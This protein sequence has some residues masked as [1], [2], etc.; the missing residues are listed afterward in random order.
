MPDFEKL[1]LNAFSRKEYKP[2]KAKTLAR[3]LGVTDDD[4][5]SFRRALRDLIAQGKA[6][7][8]N[9]HVIKP[10]GSRSAIIG[11]YRRFQSG[12]GVVRTVPLPGQ[13][14]GEYFIGSH[15]A[16]DAVNG[17]EVQVQVHRKP[18]RT[19]Q[20]I[21]QIIEIVN[22]ATKQFVGTYFERDGQG[23]VRIDG[24]IFSHSIDVGDPGAKGAKPDDK[25]VIEL[26]RFPTVQERGEGVITE[27]LGKRG[28]PAVDQ[29]SIVR[30][31]GIPDVFPEEVLAEARV[32]TDGFREDD[33]DGRTD[34][35]AQTVITIDPA[36]A[37]DFDDAVSVEID[38]KTQH[39]LL[40]V[41]IADVAHF[42]RLGGHL[43]REARKRG[44]SVYLPQQVIPM[45]PELISNGLASLQEGKLRYVKS[46][47]IEF[48][49]K[50]QIVSTQFAN[51]AI[52]ARKRFN[53]EQVSEILTQPEC[54]AA[55]ALD[56]EISGLLTRMRDLGMILRKRR[57]KRGALE[58]S[59]PAAVLEYDA[60][61]HVTG[62][63]FAINDV[64]HQIIEEFMLAA[65][66]AV[67]THLGSKE[68]P[69]LR[70]IHPAP[71]PTKLAK[72]AEFAKILGY[73]MDGVSDRFELQRVLSASTGKPEQ[74]AVH[75]ALLRSLKQAI[76]SPL[77]E[78][79]YA[80]ASHDYCHFTS[81]IR[82][83][84]DLQVHR[85]LGQLIRTGRAGGDKD[86]LAALGEHCSKMERRAETA[87]REIVKLRLLNYLNHRIGMQMDA[88]VTGVAE[89]GFYA[90][91][92]IFPAEGLVHI[93]SLTDDYHHFD[94]SATAGN[95]IS[96]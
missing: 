56:P 71:E 23:L 78:D 51:G 1:I 84:P 36:D 59:M 2:V 35:T 61:G 10:P 81:P 18:T 94:E 32:V 79:H 88:V 34:F 12:T 17:D 89:Y 43:D 66:E 74:Y 96:G 8:G 62:A 72:F 90:Q 64:S 28:D 53:Y 92:A 39:W 7:F 30:S 40:T 42:V 86:E 33:L 77:K 82:R 21:G 44:T 6:Q 22:R 24:M 14:S 83:Y 70:R 20:G 50:G 91:G 19:N 9:A 41:H 13:E 87:E 52:R 25:V 67:A 11:I 63:H 85:Q 4:Y 93:S 49:P 31:L 55:R 69:F 54:E 58:L 45:F 75:Y 26:L 47:R 95:L 5:P 29:V 57:F 80:L 3:Q 68:I 60:K 73:K 46:A 16:L 37:R 48:T 27:V 65:N 38:P 15:H 76:Y